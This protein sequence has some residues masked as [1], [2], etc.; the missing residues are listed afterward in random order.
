VA[1]TLGRALRYQN[2]DVIAKF[3]RHFQVPEAESLALFDECKKWLWLHGLP[4]APPMVMLWEM[5]NVDEMGHTFVLYTRDYERYCQS[6]FGTFVH[7]NPTRLRDQER[8][9]RAMAGDREAY[10]R[11]QR[12]Q[13]E[14]QYGFIAD[15]LG[16]ETLQRWYVDYPLRYGKEF[17]ARFGIE[18]SAMDAAVERELHAMA[19]DDGATG[20]A[21]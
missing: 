9:Q 6:R 18:V 8:Y 5:L 17:F 20:S 19:R 14:R 3:T 1:C 4:D 7:H 15:K 11:R 21:H 10:F 13:R 2:R 16:V 12:R